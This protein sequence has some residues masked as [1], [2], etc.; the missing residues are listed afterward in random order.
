MLFVGNYH[1]SQTSYNQ[2]GYSHNNLNQ[3]EFIKILTEGPKNR[4]HLS[5]KRYSK[6]FS[7][8]YSQA[9]IVKNAKVLALRITV[10]AP[11]FPGRPSEKACM[12][13][14]SPVSLAVK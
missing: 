2:R 4:I 7:P 13:T 14:A 8:Q 1:F 12:V 11:P 6:H 10:R 3:E 5:P 9:K